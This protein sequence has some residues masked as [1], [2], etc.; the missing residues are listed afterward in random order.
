MA[1]GSHAV[2]GRQVT[3]NQS[4]LDKQQPNITQLVGTIE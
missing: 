2:A 4:P 3:V 1:A